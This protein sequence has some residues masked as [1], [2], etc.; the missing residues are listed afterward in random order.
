MP[1]ADPKIAAAIFSILDADTALSSLLSGPHEIHQD[2][3]PE[4]AVLPYVVFS[5][6]TGARTDRSFRGGH[7]RDQLWLVKGICRGR[8]AT[9]ARGIDFRCE[10]LLDEAEISLAAGRSLNMRR[11]QDVSLP[12]ADSGETIYQRGGLYRLRST[13]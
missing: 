3:A 9:V 4:K 11:E 7:V 2:Y 8:S 12:D 6:H 13:P 5:L 10:Q 1:D